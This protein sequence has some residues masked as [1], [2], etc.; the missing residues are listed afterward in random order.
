LKKL[1][2]VFLRGFEIANFTLGRLQTGETW[3]NLMNK[4][5]LA[6]VFM[7]VAVNASAQTSSLKLDA[8]QVPA[9][10]S[11]LKINEVSG[12]KQFE[13]DKDITDAKIKADGGSLSRFSLKF[14]LS[15][16]GPPVGDL[17]NK[18]QPNPDG[19]I[20]SFDTALQGAMSGRFR[21]NKQS[22]ISLGTG[23]GARTPFHGT[24]QVDVK[25]PFIGIDRTG[26]LGEMQM[27]NQ[28]SLEVATYPEYREVGQWGTLDYKSS[29]VYNFGTTP[30]AAGLDSSINY[31]MYEREY[32]T[33]DRSAGRYVVAFYPELKYNMSDKLNFSSSLAVKFINPRQRSN[34]WDMLNRTLTQ[35]LGLGYAY[36]RDIYFAPYLN[37]YPNSANM[38]S[39][40]ISFSTIF[41]IL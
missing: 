26:R 5:I 35:R 38:D 34:E 17:S 6:A 41:S 1:L 15:Y 7:T 39:T 8:T 40:T 2:A 9:Q 18:K 4:M 11:V 27:R 21:L 25:N 28:I 29:L 13:E 19:S 20:G 31:F 33:K 36:S 30:W 12:N 10:E 23:I 16:F 24:E 32:E 22:A 3:G 14:A 37:F